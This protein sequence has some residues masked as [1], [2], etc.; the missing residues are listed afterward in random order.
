MKVRYTYSTGSSVLHILAV[1]T[2]INPCAI[3]R[4]PARTIESQSTTSSCS[5]ES[6]GEPKG[7]HSGHK[8]RQFHRNFIGFVWT[9]SFVPKGNIGKLHIWFHSFKIPS[10]F[11]CSN[12][13]LRVAIHV[14]M[15][16]LFDFVW[17]C[18]FLCDTCNLWGCNFTT[19]TRKS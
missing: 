19:H 7:V 8:H 1:R 4:A 9:L 15:R 14:N 12:G 5:K 2:C 11:F 3:W 10:L 13:G 16:L 6:R 18:N 17:F